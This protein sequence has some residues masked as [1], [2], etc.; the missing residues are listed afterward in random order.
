MKSNKLNTLNVHVY[1]I[2]IRKHN[3]KIQLIMNIM[4]NYVA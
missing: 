4:C 1:S 2:I 3:I